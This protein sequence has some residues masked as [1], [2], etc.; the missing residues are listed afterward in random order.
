MN[1]GKNQDIF[2]LDS[3]YYPIRMKKNL[4]DVLIFQ[5]CGVFFRHLHYPHQC[6]FFF[7]TPFVFFLS[8]PILVMRS[9]K[10]A[11]SFLPNC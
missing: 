8:F 7:F 9:I 1:E 10:V 5:G 2:V 11:F 6:I 4:L 3:V